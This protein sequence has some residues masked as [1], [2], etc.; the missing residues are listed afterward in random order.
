MDKTAKRKAEIYAR[1]GI[2]LGDKLM[3][4]KEKQDELEKLRVELQGIQRAE[5]RSPK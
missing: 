4:K 1:I 3:T 2:L 5:G